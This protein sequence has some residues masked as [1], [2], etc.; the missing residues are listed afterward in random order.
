[1]TLPHLSEDIRILI[2]LL[3]KH[4]VEYLIVGE[5]AV[6]YYGYPRYTGNVDIYNPDKN[7]VKKLFECLTEFW[8]GNIPGIN[9]PSELEHPGIIVHFGLTPN[10]VDLINQIDGVTFKEAWDNV[11]KDKLTD[12]KGETSSRIN[13]INLKHLRINKQ[14]SVRQKDKDDLE[15][16]RGF[17]R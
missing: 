13:I 7:N 3:N 14:K 11:I 9:N 15:H 5:I 12:K 17:K 1:M 4:N 10:R 6:I 16:L 2:Q 8:D